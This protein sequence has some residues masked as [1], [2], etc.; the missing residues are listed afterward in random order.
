M[1]LFYLD[2]DPAFAAE[3]HCD[4]HVV[5][6]ILEYG[7]LLSTAHRLISGE[8]MEW[9]VNGK[10]LKFYRLPDEVCYPV[11]NDGKLSI[12]VENRRVYNASHINHPSGVWARQNFRQYEWLYHLFCDLL[13]EYTHRYGKVHTAERLKS[14]LGGPRMIIKNSEFQHPPQC[15]PEEFKDN[16][17]VTAYQNYYVGAKAR[18]A[19][20]TNRSVPSWFAERITNYDKA[21]F[22][23]TRRVA[24]TALE[25]C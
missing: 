9:N 2:E 17:P 16:D 14:T 24:P 7:Q 8:L 10:K 25:G 4:K 5:K 20:W 22:S 18:F 11:C 23:R 15:M 21:H 13:R 19:C 12:E 6:M 1:N 3:M